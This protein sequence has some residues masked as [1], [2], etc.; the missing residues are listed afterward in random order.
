MR[1]GGILLIGDNTQ[2]RRWLFFDNHLITEE[3]KEKIKELD[4][5]DEYVVKC[6]RCEHI[7]RL[8]KEYEWI[9]NVEQEKVADYFVSDLGVE[10]T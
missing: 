2:C 5:P 7:L 8:V 9:E 10:Q 3:T 6:G 4:Y 1:N